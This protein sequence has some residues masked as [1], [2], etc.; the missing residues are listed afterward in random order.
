MITKKGLFS[1][2]KHRLLHRYSITSPSLLHRNDGLTMEYRWSNL[3]GKAKKQRFYLQLYMVVKSF[4]Y[5]AKCFMN[6]RNMLSEYG[7]SRRSSADYVKLCKNGGVNT[8]KLLIICFFFYIF[9]GTET[10]YICKIVKN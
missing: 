5:H 9:A 3:G 7:K 2:E 1:L 10:M 6:I 4:Q 8:T